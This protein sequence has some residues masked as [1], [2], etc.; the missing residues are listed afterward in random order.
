[1]PGTLYVVSTPIGNLG[2]MTPRALEV[3]KSVDF[4]AA[5]DTRVAMKLLG[6]FGI[7]KPLVSYFEHNKR[8]RGDVILARIAAGENCALTTDAGTPA[9]SDPGA[10]LVA[11]CREKGIPVVTVPGA[12]AAVAAFSLA[13]LRG[14]RFTFEGFLS[15]SK[16]SRRAH[17]QSLVN[18]TRPMI[19]YEAPHKL[20]ATLADFRDTFGEDRVLFIARELTKLHEES[21]RTTIGGA[22]ERYEQTEPRGEYVLIVA[23]GS[24]PET[25]P[26][27]AVA[28]ARARVAEGMSPSEAARV[29]SRETNM[30]RNAI[31]KALLE[32]TEL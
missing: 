5:E 32:D 18:E 9:I 30:P 31:Y 2:D 15:V 25:P 21:F 26:V 6:C 19:F 3:L 14:A 10:E 8:A 27:D 4:V 1:M 20:R 16:P 11:Q 17:L 29:T 7:Q 28:A 12:C 23:G 24:E 13:G 22:I